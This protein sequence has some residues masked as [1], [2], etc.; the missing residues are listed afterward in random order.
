MRILLIR[1]GRQ[2]SAL[3]NVDVPL[4]EEGRRQ[5]EL[6]GERLK[7][8][9]VDAVWSSDLI[10]AVETADIINNY[11]NVP[12]E[13]RSD[14]KEISFGDM[15]GLS[16]AEIADIFEEFLRLRAKMEK[17]MPYPGGESASDVVKRAV[18]VIKEICE[19]DYETVAVVTHGGVIRSLVAHYLGMD[20]AKV[21]LLA[22]HLENCGITE[23]WVRKHDRR[24]ILN[25]FNDASHLEVCPELMRSGWRGKK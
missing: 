2:N 5:A 25:R 21:P 22:S 13:I 4:A 3:C 8:E 19:S 12:R 7:H 1:H 17:D 11:L 9:H 14:L 18:P 10:R 15:E 16:D 23:F 24:M 6:L 20:L